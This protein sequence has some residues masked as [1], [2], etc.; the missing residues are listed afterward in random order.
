MKSLKMMLLL[1]LLLGSVSAS[2]MTYE[3]YKWLKNIAMLQ[4]VRWR[5]LH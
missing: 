2:A 3:K 4:R 1:V 5:P